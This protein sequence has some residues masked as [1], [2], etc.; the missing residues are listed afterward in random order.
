ML[1]AFS[2]P[3]ARFLWTLWHKENVKTSTY[4]V[5]LTAVSSGIWHAKLVILQW[6]VTFFYSTVSS[7]FQAWWLFS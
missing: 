3:S 7:D 1:P 5:A 6:F 4:H 2:E